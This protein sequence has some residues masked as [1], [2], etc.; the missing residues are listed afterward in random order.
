[1][2]LRTRDAHRL[3]RVGAGAA[4]R[5]RGGAVRRAAHHPGEQR[6]DQLREAHDG[7]HGRR[8]RA[9][10]GHQ[11]RLRVPPL[12]ARAPA[13]RGGVRRRRRQRRPRLLRLRRRRRLHGRHLRHGQRR[14]E[15][16]GQEPGV[17]VGQGRHQGQL[18]RAVVHQD[19]T[20]ARRPVEGGVCGEHRA[21]DAAAA[22]RRAGGGVG[23]GGVPLHALRLL[24]HRTDHR[25]RRRHDRQ[26]PLPGSTRLD[27]E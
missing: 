26:R 10:H 20:R 15:P 18:R 13:A 5:G 12:P 2:E 14:H 24:H 7:V 6:G 8:L 25:R 4:G 9:A 16:A 27:E 22:R 11:P 23:A 17:R 1:S 3:R 21:P 19:P